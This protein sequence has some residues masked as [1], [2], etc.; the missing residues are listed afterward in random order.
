VRLRAI[1]NAMLAPARV[2]PLNGRAA[3]GFISA[4][5]AEAHSTVDPL[6]CKVYSI[7]SRMPV[8]S[9]MLEISGGKPSAGR[10]GRRDVRPPS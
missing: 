2:E 5:T 8:R 1:F 6:Y 10:P 4:M 7:Y 9:T 3:P